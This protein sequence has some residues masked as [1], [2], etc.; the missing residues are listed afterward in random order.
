M[1]NI[2]DKP[3]ALV[4]GGTNP[5]IELICQLKKRGFKTILVDYTKNPPAKAYADE[6]IQ[7]S[8]LDKETVLRIAREMKADLVIS[9]CIDQANSTCCYVSEKLFLP[10]PYSYETSINV[11][12][13]SK[14]KKI[15]K[16]NDIPTSWYQTT[17]NVDSIDWDQVSFPAVVKPVDCN[18]SKG[19]H[20]VNTIDEAKKFLVEAIKL[21]R[22]KEA[23]IEGFVNG[24]EIQIDCFAENSDAKVILTR[25]KKQILRD[26]GEELNSTGSI[27]PALVCKGLE[28]SLHVIAKS[29]AKAFNLKNTPFFYQAIVDEQG[30]VNV[31]E[32]APRIGG[33]LSYYVLN[34]IAG[35]NAIHYLINSYLGIEE[36]LKYKTVDRF[37][38]TNLLYMDEGVFDHIIGFED[39]VKTGIIKKFF[40][41]KE[42]G[43]E[44][45]KDMRS[46]NRVGAF[47]VEAD[48]FTELL[49]KESEV[50]K[51]I[52]VIDINGGSKMR[53]LKS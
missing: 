22:S 53:R 15:M 18:S 36:S 51:M 28:E 34:D 38:S 32:F 7:E 23:I 2:V 13:K 25:Q 29:I 48:S 10:H 8:T 39:S 9:A 37:Y 43:T 16:D 4:L 30:N 26:N 21:S 6:H 14:M 45:S 35:F 3:I 31:L 1:I 40:I 17:Y 42:K 24:T 49:R 19:V 46:G 33:G 41:L 11:T 27:I 44:I 47:I 50:Y 5:H 12:V 52:D 20:K